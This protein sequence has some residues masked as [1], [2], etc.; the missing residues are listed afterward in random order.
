[1]F[2][3]L[4]VNST[5]LNYSTMFSRLICFMLRS[6]RENHAWMDKYPL[7][8]EQIQAIETLWEAVEGGG[9]DQAVIEAIHDLALRLFCKER[10]KVQDGDFACSVYR[11]LIVVSLTKGGGFW[12][13]TRT[14]LDDNFWPGSD[15]CLECSEKVWL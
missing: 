14:F 5:L 15:C 12:G 8:Y 13:Q 4:Q 9:S 10:N 11:F 2:S 6:V 3:A 7:D 1:M